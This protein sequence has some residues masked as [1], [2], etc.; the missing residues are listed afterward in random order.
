MSI[1]H[2]LSTAWRLVPVLILAG[3]QGASDSSSGDSAGNVGCE[4]GG[5]AANTACYQVQ[6]V[7]QWK[8]ADHGALP[9]GAHFTSPVIASHSDAYSLFKAG[10]SYASAGLELL[11]ERGKTATLINEM[12]GDNGVKCRTTMS[13]FSSP[14]A[15]A[16]AN[17]TL[18]TS[19]ALISLASMV[20][21]T[22]DWFLGVGGLSVL[23]EAGAFRDDLSAD[24]HTYDAGTE[25]GSGFS[26]SN[27]ATEPPEAVDYLS[28]SGT[29]FTS[30]SSERIEPPLARV[31]LTKISDGSCP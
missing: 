21:P 6:L 11:A 24:V 16:S 5:D 4:G 7:G 13:G 31:T 20:A 17:I 2:F 30:Q 10:E 3:C 18:T 23:D 9:G 25:E 27:A 8:A 14:T 19:H 26:L 22:P 28:P 15:Q 29:G 1:K 12:A